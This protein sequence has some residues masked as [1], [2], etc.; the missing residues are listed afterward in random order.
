MD[1]NSIYLRNEDFMIT[2]F[3]IVRNEENVKL[4]EY[5]EG[6][7][8]TFLLSEDGVSLGDSYLYDS[9]EQ[10]ND[11]LKNSINT[12]EKHSITKTDPDLANYLKN[13]KECKVVQ[14]TVIVTVTVV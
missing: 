7:N 13:L 5:D 1:E 4:T 6:G 3:K 8:G 10:A 9:A 14:V 12:A 11:C 2:K